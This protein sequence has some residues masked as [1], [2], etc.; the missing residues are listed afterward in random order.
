MT[1]ISILKT[2]P[3]YRTI[4]LIHLL[5]HIYVFTSCLKWRLIIY[6]SVTYCVYLKM[7]GIGPRYKT[8]LKLNKYDPMWSVASVCHYNIPIFLSNSHIIISGFFLALILGISLAVDFI[9][10]TNDCE[11]HCN[12]FKFVPQHLYWTFFAHTAWKTNGWL[13]K[14][15]EPGLRNLKHR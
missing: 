12:F 8:E 2:H 14:I 10:I 15:S 3:S 11:L 1:P 6:Q 13:A 4:I 7:S 5:C 9:P